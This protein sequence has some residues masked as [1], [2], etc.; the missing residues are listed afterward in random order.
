MMVHVTVHP[1]AAV[2]R[3]PAALDSTQFAPADMRLKFGRT[4][5]I[6]GEASFPNTIIENTSQLLQAEFSFYR[7]R[8]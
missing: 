5:S 2:S 6:F 7:T 3:G 8:R 4:R 1:T